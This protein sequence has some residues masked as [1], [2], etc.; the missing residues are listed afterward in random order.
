M[1]SIAIVIVYLPKLSDDDKLLIKKLSDVGVCEFIDTGLTNIFSRV[2]RVNKNDLI[3]NGFT[4][5]NFAERANEESDASYKGRLQAEVT[6]TLNILKSG[7][8]D[9]AFISEKGFYYLSQLTEFM[10]S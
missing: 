7:G 8:K 3:E 2:R 4:V 9:C 6:S 10:E 1:N 5:W